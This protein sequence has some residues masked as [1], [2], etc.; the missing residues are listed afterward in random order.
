VNEA[1]IYESCDDDQLQMLHSISE[2]FEAAIRLEASTRLEPYLFEAGEYLRERLFC[3]LLS[4]ELE[5]RNSRGD[6]PLIEEVCERFRDRQPDVQSV[7][8]AL[9]SQKAHQGK[10]AA[11]FSLTNSN[12]DV[13]TGDVIAERYTLSKVIGIGGMGCVYLAEQ[14]EPVRR[15]VAL[16]VIKTGM[17]SKTVVARFD[18]ER[19]TLAM[20][21]H[22]NIAKV[23]DGGTTVEGKSFFVME[24]VQG[25]PITTYCDEERLSV[26]DRLKLFVLVAEAVQHAHT[27][28]IIHRDIKP[29]NI[30]VATVDGRPCPKIIDF[31]VAKATEQKFS[32]LDPGATASIV[33]TPAYMSPEQA[34]PTVKDVDAR[35]DVYS[36]GVLLYEL[37]VGSPPH[38][39]QDST[40]DRVADLLRTV[41]DSDS[42]LPSSKLSLNPSLQIIAKNRDI[43]PKKLTRML[44]RE[45]DCVVVKALQRDRELRYTT[46]YTLAADIR[47]FLAGEIVEAQTPTA[48]YLLRKL[49]RKHYGT[50]IAAGL[51]FFALVAGLTGIAWGF[52]E[53][54][55]QEIAAKQEVVKTENALQR[56]AKERAFAEAIA[57]FVEKDFLALT[58]LEGQID[59]DGQN[60]KLD[61]SSTLRDLLDRA[62]LKLS[63]R[64]DLE[65]QTESRLQTMIGSSYQY[66]GAFDLAILAFQRALELNQSVL[67]E[68]GL[69]TISAKNNLAGALQA[70]GQL[71]LALPILEENLQKAQSLLGE[72]H[73]QTLLSRHLM[74]THLRKSGQPEKAVAIL[75]QTLE[76]RRSLQGPDSQATLTNMYNLAL[77]YYQAE[78]R[79]KAVA[80]MGETL[81]LQIASFGKDHPDVYV[82][83]GQLAS[84][85]RDAGQF[86]KAIPLMEQAFE[87][88]KSEY[89]EKNPPF[90]FA[91]AKLAAGYRDSGKIDLAIPRFEQAL[92]TAKVVFGPEHPDVANAMTSLAMG[93]RAKGKPEEAL[94][95]F[96][97]ALALR[98]SVLGNDH[99]STL[100]SMV[101]VAACNGAMGR[102]E[103]AAEMNERCLEQ[104]TNTLGAN[105]GTTLTIMQNLANNYWKMKKLDR[106]IPM[107]EKVLQGKEEKYGRDYPETLASI[108]NLGVNYRDAA[109]YEESIQLL[110]EVYGASA[111]IPNLSFVGIELLDAYWLSGRTEQGTKLLEDVLVAIRKKNPENSSQLAG[112][113]A[114][115]GQVLVRSKAFVEAEPL[116]RESMSIRKQLQPEE[117]R[118]F[119]I[120]A[121]LGE[122]LCGQGKHGDAELLLLAGYEG[123]NQRTATAPFGS[124]ERLRKTIDCLVDL[125]AVVGRVEEL[126]KWNKVRNQFDENHSAESRR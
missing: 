83:M 56:E 96:E 36:L 25:L 4:I 57:E 1:G 12:A 37:L 79:V 55:K 24:L 62:V 16:K 10:N 39:N 91:L 75:E 54:R 14:H 53:A 104:A 19:Q 113:L 110:E 49:A 97:Q 87:W 48:S 73:R 2:R 93:Y 13:T 8:A 42:P 70:N 80:L 27:K 30:L 105:H 34:D 72:H 103:K 67:G 118:T 108:A 51:V 123:M 90:V 38:E 35:T 50:V 124:D 82:T 11:L 52:L 81:K 116:L 40:R 63:S 117:W 98:T 61:R 59:Q 77:A 47:R 26:E 111:K 86:D 76:L 112:Q 32:T 84:Y 106:S 31:G 74:A 119:S 18:A 41:R 33:G 114:T 95:L 3:E 66:L 64:S 5:W 7:F 125:Y 85:Y 122:A 101:N 71:E 15:Q 121:M 20:M 43:D 69:N 21:E 45:L 29:A 78:Q 46:A 94:P 58:S 28:G 65:P 89:G 120:I 109:R 115:I 99:P 102:I 68:E 60:A 107:F 92:E 44:R 100:V 23:Y 126:S 9:E 17:D 6:S 88:T 22:A